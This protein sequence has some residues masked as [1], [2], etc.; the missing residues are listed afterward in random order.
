MRAGFSH[1]EK[2]GHCN[3]WGHRAKGAE[4]KWG[5]S[6]E[7]KFGVTA[8]DHKAKARREKVDVKGQKEGSKG[9]GNGQ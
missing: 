3:R 8:S 5:K 7:L 9:K 1:G 6:K 2:K 4:M